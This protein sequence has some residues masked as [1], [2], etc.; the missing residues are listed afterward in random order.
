M[1]EKMHGSLVFQLQQMLEFKQISQTNTKTI[2][3]PSPNIRSQKI[4]ENYST[5][6]LHSKFSM[7]SQQNIQYEKSANNLN[8]IF[9]FLT[10]I[11]YT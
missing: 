10:L 11:L 4:I 2:F 9:Q 1:A 8:N 5:R 6:Y 7:K 3:I